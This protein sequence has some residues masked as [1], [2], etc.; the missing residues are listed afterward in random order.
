MPWWT[1]R[2]KTITSPV[3]IRSCLESAEPLLLLGTNMIAPLGMMQPGHACRGQRKRRKLALPYHG[4][5]RILEVRPNTL[6]VRP[7]DRVDLKPILVSM[8]WV[9][10]C[11]DELPNKSWLGP[12]G[13]KRIPE[14][15]GKASK[16]DKPDEGPGGTSLPIEIQR[17]YSQGREFLSEGGNVTLEL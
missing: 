13:K 17:N 2:E 4:P 5:Y 12:H 6:L 11:S 16:R 15:E 8:D 9:V 10:C 1:W 3:Y 14:E 7:V